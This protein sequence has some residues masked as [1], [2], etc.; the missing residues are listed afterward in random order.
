MT[1]TK[2]SVGSS[3]PEM[4]AINASASRGLKI[5]RHIAF[6]FGPVFVVVLK[7]FHVGKPRPQASQSLL[8]YGDRMDAAAGVALPSQDA[9][10][11]TRAI[12][13]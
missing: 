2:R 5:L 12:I 13:A 7:A 8:Q 3:E 9:H 4:A 6:P 11:S 1:S 10:D